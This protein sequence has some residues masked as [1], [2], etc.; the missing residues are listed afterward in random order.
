M[1]L[2]KM[3]TRFRVGWYRCRL[4]YE[5]KREKVSKLQ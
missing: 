1:G 5:S 2:Y 4:D 3:E